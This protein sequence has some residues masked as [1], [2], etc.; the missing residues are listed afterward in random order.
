LA[1]KLSAHKP[2]AI[3]ILFIVVVIAVVH[4]FNLKIPY[5]MSRHLVAQMQKRLTALP[6]AKPYPAH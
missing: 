1:A 2:A 3:T 5:A 4:Y 6:A